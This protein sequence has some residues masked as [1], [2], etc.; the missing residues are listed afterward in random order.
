METVSLR[1][2]TPPLE[3]RVGH[4]SQGGSART[5]GRH[6]C[7][8][9]KQGTGPDNPWALD[10]L[11]AVT[12][13]TG[14]RDDVAPGG[15]VLGALR[16]C[17]WEHPASDEEPTLLLPELLAAVDA[18]CETGS[19]RRLRPERA[20]LTLVFVK[21]GFFYVAR[22]GAAPAYLLRGDTLRALAALPTTSKSGSSA[23]DSHVPRVESGLLE[24]GDA[25]LCANI[26]LERWLEPADIRRALTQSLSP[27]AAAARLAEQASDRGAPDPAVAVLFAGDGPSVGPRT[28]RSGAFVITPPP[29]API[30][31]TVPAVAMTATVAPPRRKG[32]NIGMVVAGLLGALLGIGGGVALV[33]A[34]LQP[35]DSPGPATIRAEVQDAPPPY[36]ASFVPASPEATQTAPETTAPSNS[37]VAPT[38][39]APSAVVPAIPNAAPPPLTPATPIRRL[40]GATRPGNNAPAA[41]P[42]V[43]LAA[44]MSARVTLQATLD[45]ARGMLLLT[46]NQGI[47]YSPEAP[48]GVPVGTALGIVLDGAIRERLADGRGELRLE[49]VP[50]NGIT[51]AIRGEELERLVHGGPVALADVPPGEY[52]LAAAHPDQPPFVSPTAGL[53]VGGL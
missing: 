44:G 41:P 1:V 25:L 17:M 45:P 36:V 28:E 24:E 21:R 16:E 29:T 53:R 38:G 8:A 15:L 48:K 20:L 26:D 34:L 6:A 46:A 35:G 19:V 31:P 52:R 51:P 23:S 43:P 12:G 10:A 32:P 14:G 5:V 33:V 47:L 3:L 2:D 42:V 18:R 37:T 13:D 49:P 11:L 27:R 9:Q 22:E 39:T 4:H 7:L 30:A 40:G 50:A